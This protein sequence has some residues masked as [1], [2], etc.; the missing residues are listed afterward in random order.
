MSHDMRTA[1]RAAGARER[2][3]NRGSEGRSERACERMARR[4]RSN[5]KVMETGRNDGDKKWEQKGETKNGDSDRDRGVETN[6]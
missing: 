5:T 3:S 2:R 4:L 6:S 1:L